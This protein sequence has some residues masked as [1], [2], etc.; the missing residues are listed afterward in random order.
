MYVLSISEQRIDGR[1]QQAQ[2]VQRRRQRSWQRRGQDGPLGGE[3]FSPSSSR[4]RPWRGLGGRPDRVR[5]LAGPQDHLALR[6]GDHPVCRERQVLPGARQRRLGEAEVLRPPMPPRTPP[7]SHEP[8]R[9]EAVQVSAVRR[10]FAQE[11]RASLQHPAQ[12]GARGGEGGRRRGCQGSERTSRP[13]AAFRSAG[14]SNSFPGSPSRRRFRVRGRRLRPTHRLGL[15]AELEFAVRAGPPEQQRA[16]G[17]GGPRDACA[18]RP[19][20]DGVGVGHRWPPG[21]REAAGP[22]RAGRLRAHP[23]R[24]ELVGRAGSAAPPAP[25]RLAPSPAAVTSGPPVVRPRAA[26]SWSIITLETRDGGSAIEVSLG[27]PRSN[28]LYNKCRNCE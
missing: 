26:P 17:L 10:P 4:R 11:I 13:S 14:K 19:G 9:R 21:G 3:Q 28:T 16:V 18:G 22:Y 8:V 6:P 25:A 2:V 7:Q 24:P 20:G 12:N 23:G 1:R 15:R 27:A 5:L